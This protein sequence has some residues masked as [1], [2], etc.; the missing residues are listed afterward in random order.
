VSQTGDVTVETVWLPESRRARIVVS[1]DGPGITDEDKERLFVPYFSTK[2]TGMGLGLPIVHQI[3]TDH[4]GTIWVEDNPPH[5]SRF[6]IELPGR[7][8]A[9][10]SRRGVTHVGRAHLD[11]GRRAGD[12]DELPRGARGRGLSG[13][14][15]GVGVG[16]AAASQ[17]EAPDLIFL[18]IWMPGI[19]GLEALA[20]IKRLRPETAVV[21]ISGHATIE[22]AVK[23]T[24]LGAYD[25]IEKPLS[26]E[27][28]L[29]AASRALDHGRLERQNRDLREQLERG[30]RIVGQSRVVEEMRQQIAIAAPTNGRVLITARTGRGRSWSPA[31]S[32]PSRRAARAPSSR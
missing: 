18:D 3:V 2:A 31:P 16:G 8:R 14:R 27:K 4:G 15:G 12:P 24:K 9:R 23:A 17:D 20:E 10:G 5:G 1:D 32:T 11:R 22:T 25:F 21:M 13:V 7:A 26:L 28:T 29:L 6:V 19:D 30:Q